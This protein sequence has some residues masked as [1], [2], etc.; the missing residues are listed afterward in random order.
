MND[1]SLSEALGLIYETAVAPA[2]WSVLLQRLVRNFGCH[3]SG[4][5]ISSANRDEC[6][7]MIV[8]VDHIEDQTFLHRFNRTNPIY[9]RSQHI[10][11][12]EPEDASTVIARREFEWMEMYQAFF[13]PNDMGHLGRMT[14]CSGRAGTQTVAL[15]RPWRAAEFGEQ[16]RSLARVLM[17]HLQRAAMATRHL[18]GADLRTQAAHATLDTLPHPV[19]LLDRTGRPIHANREADQL[20][21]TADGLLA[22]RGTLSGAAPAAT[23]ALHALI[24]AAA[25][26]RGKGGTLRLPRPSGRAPLALVAIPVRGLH[27]FFFA[28]QP[29]VILCV[30]DPTS[31]A[32]IDP[33]ALIVLF[34]LTRAEAELAN[35]LLAGHELPAIAGSTGRSVHTVRNLLVRAPAAA[36][37]E[38]ARPNSVCTPCH[39]GPGRGQAAG[40]GGGNAAARSPSPSALRAFNLSRAAGEVIR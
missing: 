16:E 10:R 27:D 37:N 33:T 30:A 6:R 18:H 34:G 20:L 23:R 1:A 4:M 11:A 39:A 15:S 12:T 2:T 8:G 38:A 32:T 3:V 13:C 28:D 14:I 19:V 24:G 25:C 7:A 31:R 40:A 9:L 5:N 29:A 17:P 36:L 35:Q 22:S 26:S 21:R